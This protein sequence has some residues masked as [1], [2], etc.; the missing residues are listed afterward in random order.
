MSE[1][2]S[3]LL[4]IMSALRDPVSGCPWDLKQSY[5][6]I[7]PYTLEEAYEVADAIARDSFDELKDELGDLLFQVVFYAQLAK[8]EG[9]FQFEDC[10]TAICDKLE[11]RHP[12]V[13]GNLR[14]EDADTVLK[15]W[16]ALK[17]TERKESGQ[18]SVLDNIPQAMPALSRAYKLQK[19]CANVGFDW[20]DVSGCWNKVKEEI[21][22]VEQTAPG[23][24]ELTEELGDLMF[25]L[26]NV[27]RKHKLDP[28]AVL[29]AANSKFEKRFRAVELTLAEQGRST[30]QATLDEMEQI[31]Q[32]VKRQPS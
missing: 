23:S 16:E 29:R 21:L 22:E 17:S 20:P 7:V 12:H 30:E 11:R 27:V 19:R 9:R 1:P 28:E 2:I 13:F 31:W 15:N 5:A 3:R 6:S 32:Q 18:H 25:A 4:S 26:V 14:A 10:V 8:E 24:A